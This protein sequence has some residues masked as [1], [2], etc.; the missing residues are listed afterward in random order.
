MRQ[1]LRLIGKAEHGIRTSTIDLGL[2]GRGLIGT[3]RLARAHPLAARALAAAASIYALRQPQ[4]TPGNSRDALPVRHA[5]LFQLFEALTQHELHER[6]WKAPNAAPRTR[7]C[8]SKLCTCWPE[9]P[10]R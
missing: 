7:T 5:V 10:N 4:P 9:H 2:S 8:R 1:T 3:A 6:A